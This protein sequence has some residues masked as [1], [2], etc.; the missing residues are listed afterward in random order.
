ML[1]NQAFDN[2]GLKSETANVKIATAII[3]AI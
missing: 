2:A 1:Y 3:D